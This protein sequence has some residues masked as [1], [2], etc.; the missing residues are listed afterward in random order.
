[1]NA[2]FRL[3]HAELDALDEVQGPRIAVVI[4]CYRVSRQVVDLIARIGPECSAIYAVDDCCPEKSGDV[5]EAACSD[6]RLRVIRHSANQGV[7]GA[8]VT[9]FRA[10]LADGADIIV[11]LDGDGQ[12]DPDLIPAFAA[13]IAQGQADY[14][15][16]NRFFS[17]EDVQGMPKGRLF[18]NLALSFLTKLSSGYWTLFDPNNGYVAID[19]RV[20][21]HVPLDKVER[22]YFFESD[23]LFRLG[24]LRARVIDLPME[25]VYEDEVSSLNPLKMV[26]H[27][28]R[29]HLV[30]TFK[31]I[32]YSYFLRDFSIASIELVAGILLLG[33]GLIFGGFT[34][35]AN[36]QAGV[37]TPIGTVMLAAL[38]VLMGLQFLLAF[39]GYDIA[40]APAHPVGPLIARA[41]WQYHSR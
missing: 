17:P 13:P 39:I 41:H 25:A 5:I 7:G 4:P 27:F 23:M 40:N 8:M 26:P 35:I 36:L 14:V 15:K 2:P 22:R 19:A 20:L 21:T 38:P 18:G 34:W 12:M 6:R 29:R 31:R 16:G 10:A 9:G 11:K 33:F 32:S 28:A 1:M 24:T 3:G 30:N 37:A